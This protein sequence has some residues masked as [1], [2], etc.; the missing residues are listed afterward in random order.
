M[1][2]MFY[3]KIIALI[4]SVCISMLLIFKLSINAQ[5]ATNQK[6]INNYTNYIIT[7]PKSNIALSIALKTK[8]I[9]I[10]PIEVRVKG[11]TE[12]MDIAYIYPEGYGKEFAIHG[13]YQNYLNTVIIKGNGIDIQTNIKTGSLP[14]KARDTVTINIDKLNITND[15]FNQDLYFYNSSASAYIAAID[16]KGDIRYYYDSSKMHLY[17]IYFDKDIN[18]VLLKY[19]EGVHDLLGNKIV[20]FPNNIEFHHDAIEYNDNYLALVNSKWGVED[21]LIELTKDGTI[22]ND[23]TFGDLFRDI[24]KNN[25]NDMETLNKI[26]YDEKNIYVNEKTGKKEAV[27]WIHANSLTYDDDKKI[28]YVS[29]RNQAVAAIDYENWKLIWWMADNSLDTGRWTYMLA[30][31]NQGYNFLKIQSLEPYRVQGDGATDGPKNQHALIIT[32]EGNIGMFDNQGDSPENT[33]GSRY[34]EYEIT[35]EH[36]SYSAIKGREYRDPKLY[37]RFFCDVDFVGENNANIL[38]NFGYLGRILEIDENKNTLFDAKINMKNFIYRTDK[39]PL[40]PYSDESKFYPIE[41][42]EKENL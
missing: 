18:K 3:K 23:K 15:A 40:Y 6:K 31:P 13:L 21:R 29:F 8:D 17:S 25:P 39:M 32:K 26:I 20:A 37:S 19:N 2:K 22:V 24:A 33:K 30:I 41:H 28:L 12:D 36:G 5:D 7:K 35:G 1:N 14:K 9:N 10:E 11:K 16:R 34:V 42:N 38:L 27:N 4:F